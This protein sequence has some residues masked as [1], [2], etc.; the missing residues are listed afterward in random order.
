MQKS[1]QIADF[2]ALTCTN[3]MIR[4]KISLK[5]MDSGNALQ[6]Y[7]TREQLDNILKP[8]S[9]KPYKFSSE[10]IGDNYYLITISK[11]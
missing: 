10:K 9:K 11:H 2:T 7:S 8:F 1:S 5:K 4:L 6:F 3:L